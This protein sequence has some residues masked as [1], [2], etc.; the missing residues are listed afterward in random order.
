MLLRH[1]S[2]AVFKTKLKVIPCHRQ[3]ASH[4]KR[5]HFVGCKRNSVSVSLHLVAAC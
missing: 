2:S 3:Q 4:E 1:S 5:E